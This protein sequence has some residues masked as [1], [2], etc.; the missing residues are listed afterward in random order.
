MSNLQKDLEKLMHYEREAR[1]ILGEGT[2]NDKPE[3]APYPFTNT[4]EVEA[5]NRMKMMGGGFASAL[6]TAWL[7]ADDTNQRKLRREFV[8]LLTPY[9]AMYRRGQ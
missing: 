2:L 3:P 7:R 5:L 6:A 1:D 9:V 8:G 4:E